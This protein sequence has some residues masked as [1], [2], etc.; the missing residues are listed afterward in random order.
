MTA[1]TDNRLEDA[2]MTPVSCRQCAAQVFARK[3]TW[4]QT[5]VQWTGEAT[6]RCAELRAAQVLSGGPVAV[7]Q[8][9]SQLRES[10]WHA[11]ESGELPVL[12]PH[13]S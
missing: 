5:S 11:A 10:L 4:Q 3:S 7:L 9:C 2:P 6:A 13:P 12:D 8:H 1:R